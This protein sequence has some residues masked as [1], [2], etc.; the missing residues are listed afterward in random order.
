ME[1]AMKLLDKIYDRTTGCDFSYALTAM[2][3]S[4]YFIRLLGFWE[5]FA[6]CVSKRVSK[7]L[8]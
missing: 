5:S 3:C 8:L 4:P 6:G 2:V 1:I 7:Y